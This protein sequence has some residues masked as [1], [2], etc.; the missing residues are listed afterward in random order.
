M[1][2]LPISHK[3]LKVYLRNHCIINI[4]IYQYKFC[5]LLTINVTFSQLVLF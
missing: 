2:F 3:P 1:F 4:I 5:N